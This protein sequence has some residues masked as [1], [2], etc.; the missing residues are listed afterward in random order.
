M[1]EF[2]QLNATLR[3]GAGKRVAKRLRREGNVP[4]VYYHKDESPVELQFKLKEVQ[5]LLAK[6]TPILVLRWGDSDDQMRECVI[7]EV[8]YHPVTQLPMHIDLLGITRGVKMDATVR[9]QL[10]GTPV[11]VRSS[12]VF[13]SS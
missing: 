9:V 8:Q 4:G 5:N 11:G 7:R 6:R 10:V 2:G 12:V 13:S 1:A 3:E